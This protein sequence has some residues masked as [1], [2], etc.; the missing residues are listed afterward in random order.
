MH[1][2]HKVIH[3]G[4]EEETHPDVEHGIKIPEEQ[5]LL[6]VE[7]DVVRELFDVVGHLDQLVDGDGVGP[8]NGGELE[9]RAGPGALNK[10]LD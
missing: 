10:I 3:I 1:L 5:G 6:V 9:G 4:H 7:G 8:A 2:V